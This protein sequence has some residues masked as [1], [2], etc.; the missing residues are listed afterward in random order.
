MV[1]RAQ[2][3][4][5]REAADRL[6]AKIRT[7]VAEQLDEQEAVLFAALVAPGVA[8]A[9]DDG[10]VVGFSGDGSGPDQGGGDVDWDPDALPAALAAAV[11]DAGIRIEGLA[12]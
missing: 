10:E 3:P 9:Y 11:R 1:E 6:L 12:G 4:A 5:Q 2:D 8:S 7:F